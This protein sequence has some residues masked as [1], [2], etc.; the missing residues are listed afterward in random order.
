MIENIQ[1]LKRRII[2]LKFSQMKI[3]KINVRLKSVQIIINYNK[4]LKISVTLK[5]WLRKQL[6]LILRHSKFNNKKIKIP[7]KLR[8]FSIN[9]TLIKMQIQI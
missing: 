9:T 7:L 8:I 1:Q 6:K 5:F 3:K 4:M 2:F